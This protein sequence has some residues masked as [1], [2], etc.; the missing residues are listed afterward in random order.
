M[1][2]LLVIQLF[3]LGVAGVAVAL[4]LILCWECSTAAQQEVQ[5][6]KGA[7]TTAKQWVSTL[8]YGFKV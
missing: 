2:E 7:N 3:W 6:L 5:S 1:G 8:V 4:R